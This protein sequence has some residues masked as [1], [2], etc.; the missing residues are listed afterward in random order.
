M[1]ILGT[2]LAVYQVVGQVW[3]GIALSF[4]I[5]PLTMYFVLNKERVKVK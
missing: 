3:L 1:A 5:A 2:I 4:I